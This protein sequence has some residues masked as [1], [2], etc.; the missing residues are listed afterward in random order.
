LVLGGL[1]LVAI[2]VIRRTRAARAQ[3][4]QDVT[5]FVQ[6]LVAR[7]YDGTICR[8]TYLY[9]RDQLNIAFPI[10]PED[11]LEEDL[12]LNYEETDQVV[13][14]LLSFVDPKFR[15]GFMPTPVTVL[16]LVRTIHA[17][18]SRMRLVA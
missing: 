16:D 10:T 14:T 4:G 11:R 3:K 5:T 7:G 9:L 17:L 8:M 6:D 15:R 1:M 18:P 12:G 13:R 2:G